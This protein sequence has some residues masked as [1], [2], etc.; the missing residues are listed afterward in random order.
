MDIQNHYYGHSAVMAA[1]A[2]LSRPRHV[3]GLLQHGWTATSPVDAHFADFPLV[4]RDPK[5]RRLLVWS[6]ASRAWSPSEQ[7]RP[8]TA[9]GAQAVECGHAESGRKAAITRASRPALA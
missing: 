3:A 2:G 5:R 6:H 9:V 8:T 1:Y 7:D 4:G